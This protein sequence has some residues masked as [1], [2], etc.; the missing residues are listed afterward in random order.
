MSWKST[1]SVFL[2]ICRT[3]INLKIK[4]KIDFNS[5]NPAVEK[6]GTFTIG[7]IPFYCGTWAKEIVYCLLVT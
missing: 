4:T 7:F 3:N 6:H 5:G 2:K 1:D